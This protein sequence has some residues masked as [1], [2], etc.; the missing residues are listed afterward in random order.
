MIDSG[1]ERALLKNKSSRDEDV[2][3][4]RLDG[5]ATTVKDPSRVDDTSR[6]IL[7]EFDP[8]SSRE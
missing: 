2:S 6:K 8:S 4:P 5:E 3:D 1:K 7:D